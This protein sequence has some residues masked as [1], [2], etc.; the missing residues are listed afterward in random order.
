[1]AGRLGSLRYSRCSRNNQPNPRSDRIRGI[2]VRFLL[3][4]SDG[5]N[6][7]RFRQLHHAEYRKYFRSSKRRNA[8]RY[9]YHDHELFRTGRLPHQLF[10]MDYPLQGTSLCKQKPSTST[11]NREITRLDVKPGSTSIDYKSSL[12]SPSPISRG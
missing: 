9:P 5:P 10:H 4:Y 11:G 12:L 2:R 3:E 6:E 1:M 7:K 8:G